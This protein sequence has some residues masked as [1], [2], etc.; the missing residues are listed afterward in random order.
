M[1]TKRWYKGGCLHQRLGEP[2]SLCWLRP[3]NVGASKFIGH[4]QIY[5]SIS[6]PLTMTMAALL[7]MNQFN[8]HD[9]E[10]MLQALFDL[11]FP[12]DQKSVNQCQ[13]KNYLGNLFFKRE[14]LGAPTLRFWFIRSRG[15]Y[16]PETNTFNKR[17]QMNLIQSGYGTNM[18]ISNFQTEFPSRNTEQGLFTF[19]RHS[20]DTALVGV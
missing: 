12:V 8:R 19:V 7:M 3:R 11:Y 17:P 13:G 6:G 18:Q 9:D 4:L 16:D 15:W 14:V 5:A 1:S 2:V 20:K 10:P